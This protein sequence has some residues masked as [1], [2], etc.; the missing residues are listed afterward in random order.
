MDG[1]AQ[2]GVAR[3]I[4]WIGQFVLKSSRGVFKISVQTSQQAVSVSFPWLST[5]A[6]SSYLNPS[7]ALWLC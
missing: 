7:T 4:L 2:I 1:N 5:S 6:C 3:V